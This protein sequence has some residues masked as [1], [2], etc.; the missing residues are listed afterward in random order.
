MS[1]EQKDDLLRS[2]LTLRN[3]P[4]PL[5]K[6]EVVQ[7]GVRLSGLCEGE[8]TDYIE[9]FEDSLTVLVGGV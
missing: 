2:I 9:E 1:F 3:T 4:S 6:D 8:I 5:S 7:I